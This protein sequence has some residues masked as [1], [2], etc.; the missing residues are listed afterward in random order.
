MHSFTN[1]RLSVQQKS[2]QFYMSRISFLLKLK[3]ALTCRQATTNKEAWKQLVR[4][5]ITVLNICIDPFYFFSMKFNETPKVSA[6][7][8]SY[9]N[10][11]FL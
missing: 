6:L 9:G 3:F 10:Y 2:T 4:A 7:P 5:L 11:E 8:V 1:K